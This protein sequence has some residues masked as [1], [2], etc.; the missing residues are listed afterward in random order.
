MKSDELK[1]AF[2]SSLRTCHS[3]AFLVTR[4]S[5]P[6]LDNTYGS[7]RKARECALQMLFAA[8]V[9][10][11]RVRRVVRRLLGRAGDAEMDDTARAFATRLARRPRAHAEPTSASARAPSRRIS[12]MAV[13]DRTSSG[14][15]F[16]FL[17]EPT[18]RTVAI[19]ERLE[20]PAGSH[21]RGHAVH[22]RHP[23]RHQT[24]PTRSAAGVGRRRAGGRGRRGTTRARRKTTT[25]PERLGLTSGCAAAATS[26]PAAER[27]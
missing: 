27:R 20:S 22:Q 15:P 10:V 1:T 14:S 24:G 11:R 4:H 13:V 7:R 21:L 18:P 3:F 19:N 6:G 8:D 26:R 12:R 16:E 9:T 2:C 25:T 17:Y 5:S 23:R